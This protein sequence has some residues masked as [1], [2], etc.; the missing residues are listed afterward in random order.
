MKAKR[1]SEMTATCATVTGHDDEAAV[2]APSAA[3]SSFIALSASA[4][5]YPYADQPPSATIT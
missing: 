5:M 1:H 4:Q 3:T 2:I